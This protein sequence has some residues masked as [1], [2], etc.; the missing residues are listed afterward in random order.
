MMNEKKFKNQLIEIKENN[1]AIPEDIDAYDLTLE[2]MDNIGSTDSELRDGLIFRLLMMIIRTKKISFDQMEELLTICLSERH[3]FNGV[4]KIEDDS[5]FN[6]TFTSLVIAGILRVN[7]KEQEKF[8]SESQIKHVYKEVLKYLRT[9]KDLRGYVEF[10]GWAHSTAHTAD[11]LCGLASSKG[12]DHNELL[13][14]L[15]V[16]KEKV[17]VDTYT[18]INEEDE[19]LINAF[20]CVICR[21]IVSDEEIIDWINNFQNVEDVKQCPQYEHLRINRKNFLR[22]L[23]FRLKNEDD[24]EGVLEAIEEGLS[25]LRV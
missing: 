15:Q 18:Y 10:K 2:L 25:K 7:Y 5:V 23:Y 21:E 24:A 16:I 3:L 14:I 1:W 17:C 8:L 12:I 4:G 20:I 9:E 13:E 22:S 11:M 19:R 6:R